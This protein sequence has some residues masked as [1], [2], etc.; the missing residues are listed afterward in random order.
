MIL[1]YGNRGLIRQTRRLLNDGRDVGVAISGW[2]ADLFEK[3]LP[4]LVDM[5]S[6]VHKEASPRQTK[7]STLAYAMA[8]IVLSTALAPLWT[9]F[10]IAMTH[11]RRMTMTKEAG[12]VEILFVN[13]TSPAPRAS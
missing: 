1:R 10:M 3:A 12:H 11:K 7:V 9:V 2:R 5:E 6:Y 13:T 8:L 4:V